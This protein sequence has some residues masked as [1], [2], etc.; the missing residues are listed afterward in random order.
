VVYGMPYP[1]SALVS[2][3]IASVSSSNEI[4]NCLIPMGTLGIPH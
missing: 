3:C 2:V 1:S 4:F